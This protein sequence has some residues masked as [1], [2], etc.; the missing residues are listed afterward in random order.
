M[1][2]PDP[3]SSSQPDPA[4]PTAL[5]ADGAGALPDGAAALAH[6]GAPDER[7]GMLVRRTMRLS[8]VE[9]SLTQILL[10]WTTG[11]VLV[12]YLLHLGATPTQIALASSMPLLA[13]V[14]SPFGAW[15]AEVMGRRK[16]VVAT[17]AAIGRASW[18]IGAL[19]PALAVP[20]AARPVLLVALVFFAMTFQAATAT[21]WT[22]WMGDV[23]PE[24]RRGSYFGM[25]AGVLGVVGMAANLAAGAFLDR[26]AAP[27]S[28][29]LVLGVAIVASLVAVAL[30]LFH[31]DPPT[32]QRKVGLGELFRVPLAD[33]N[34]RRFLTFA[35]YW[36]FVVMLGG[37]FVVPYWLEDLHMTFTQIAYWSTIN[38]VTA[39]LATMQ[40]GRVAD[41]IGNK[42][43]LAVGTFLAG[44]LLPTTWILAGLTG[45]LT[46]I[47]LSGFFDAIAWGAIGPSVFSLALG[48]APRSRRVTFI[49]MYSLVQG[50]AGFA[51]GALAG[52]L[53]GLLQSFSA[54]G[55][56]PA[57]SGYHSLFVVTGVGR[58]LAWLFVRRVAE[59]RAWRTRDLL[60]GGR[61][62]P[63]GSHGGRAG[64]SRRGRGRSKL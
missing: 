53:L 23:V 46:Y 43:V 45:D 49:A 61:H 55:W 7:T 44:A 27:L 54:P 52:P 10:N 35:I 37:P 18:I 28:F 24:A 39:L 20:D 16:V 34:F 42:P 12:G 30:L 59:P 36:Q 6:S 51:G 33:K 47:W 26:V 60:R 31:Y 17:L 25:R 14:A 1:S 13:Q 62:A 5:A 58:M 19:L 40:W 57:W 50:V 56:L 22:A 8:V 63:A 11:S 48:A 9:G 32:E 2:P 15:V 21:V 41:R 38:A 29:Q 64:G 3:T 4:S